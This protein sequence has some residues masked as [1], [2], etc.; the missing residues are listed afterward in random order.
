MSIK[1]DLEFIKPEVRSGWDVSSE[2][3]KVWTVQLDLIQVFDKICKL[4][5]L[6]WYPMWGTLL[7]IIR[8]KGYI[9]WD[10]D[11]DIVMPRTDYDKFVSLCNNYISKP[12]YLQTTLTDSECFYM[13]VSLRNSDTTG[14]RQ[15]CLSK[16]QNNGIGIDIMPLDGCQDTPWK[17]KISRFP[18]RI[19]TV[20]ANTYVNDFNKGFVARCIR[21]VLRNIGF[22]YKKAYEIAEKW[23]KKY[24]I[25]D[26]PK[27]A[28][29]A[30]ADPLTKII[31]RD[32][33]N[34]SDFE[35]TIDMP[36]EYI[37]MPVPNGYDNILK[38]IYGNYMEFPPFDKRAAKHDVVYEPNIPYK[39]YCI[40]H[41]NVNY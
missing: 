39:E 26:Y 32:M 9:P 15:T 13:W 37:Q 31:K 24:K 14:N 8:H 19:I 40:K 36:F 27:M 30:H 10:D 38:Q 21:R 17:Y 34:K 20:L 41:Y 29:R 7:G 25:D 11:V 16:K 2:M 35:S 1:Y 18:V 22:N 12:Y 3:K 23:N 5:K 4:N 28:F 33:W 6:R